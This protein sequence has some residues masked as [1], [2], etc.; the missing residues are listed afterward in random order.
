MIF[1]LFELAFSLL[2]FSFQFLKADLI[3]VQLELVNHQVVMNN[4]HVCQ[5]QV[6]ADYQLDFYSFCQF[7]S[8]PFDVLQFQI[9]NDPI[10]VLEFS[11]FE[12]LQKGFQ[13]EANRLSTNQRASINLETHLDHDFLH[14][15]SIF[16]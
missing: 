6:V 15:L 13:I 3:R 5:V 4:L 11:I 12:W 7:F 2:E 14:I 8:V 1:I 9:L 10:L 16:R